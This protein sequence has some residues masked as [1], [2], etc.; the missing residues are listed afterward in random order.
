MKNNNNNDYDYGELPSMLAS[1]ATS[2][3]TNIYSAG[4]Q[5]D[6]MASG[7]SSGT[8]TIFTKHIKDNLYPIYNPIKYDNPVSHITGDN[9][10]HMNDNNIHIQPANNG[11]ILTMISNHKVKIN[12][13]STFK[14]VVTFLDDNSVMDLDASEV[15]DN[16]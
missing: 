4:I 10:I 8:G 7:T 14:E 11:F 12:V 1:S 5:G 9:D 3:S 13:F 15:A 2:N 16:I 6:S